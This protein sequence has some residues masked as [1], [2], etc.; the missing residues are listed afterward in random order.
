MYHQQT[1]N[2]FVELRAQGWTLARIATHLG[3]SKR[4]L[5]DWNQACRS[6]VAAL[7]AFESEALESKLLA[8][9]ADELTRLAGH[10]KSIR[11]E[12]A[13][14]SLKSISTES[15]F[16]LDA[17]ISRQIQQLRLHPAFD[18]EPVAPANP[19]PASIS[20][21][22]IALNSPPASAAESL[23]A[24]S[25]Q[26]VPDTV[27]ALTMPPETP[28]SCNFCPFGPPTLGA[29]FKQCC[30]NQRNRY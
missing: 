1:K 7:R 5:L 15:L 24:L 3:I 30:R 27:P 25:C 9:Q 28:L 21:P 23:P 2:Q 4:T 20:A 22:E 12:L 11:A 18:S 16:R 14:R 6:E 8:S 17:L 19:G 26:H 29:E 13:T 10:Q